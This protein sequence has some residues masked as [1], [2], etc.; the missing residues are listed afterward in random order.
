M[1]FQISNTLLFNLKRTHYNGN[2]YSYVSCELEF[3]IILKFTAAGL[4]EY[5]NA[6]SVFKPNLD[7]VL[8]ETKS[9][10]NSKL[11]YFRITNTFFSTTLG[12]NKHAVNRFLYPFCV[13]G[14]GFFFVGRWERHCLICR[15]QMRPT[16]P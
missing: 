10:T 9:Y 6:I 2:I 3:W 16:L 13:P 8:R 15:L 1:H 14:K 11:F 5:L 4:I 7:G 12:T